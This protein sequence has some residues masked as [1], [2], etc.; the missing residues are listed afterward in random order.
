MSRDYPLENASA[1]GAA[2]SR[3]NR[4]HPAEIAMAWIIGGLA[5]I[6]AV[7]LGSVLVLVF[8]ATL[9]VVV[10]AAVVL[11]AFMGVAWR[12]RR[13]KVDPGVILNARKVGHSWVAYGWDQPS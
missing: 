5:V 3:T 4:A 13:P 7:A 12:L 9:A 8:A 6:G 11:L 2:L 1:G 10:L